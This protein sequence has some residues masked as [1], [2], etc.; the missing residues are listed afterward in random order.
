MKS[1][2]SSTHTVYKR[3]TCQSDLVEPD[4]SLFHPV[5]QSTGSWQT[6]NEKNREKITDKKTNRHKKK[7]TEQTNKKKE[8][9]R[10]PWEGRKLGCE[11]E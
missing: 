11:V 9:I 7:K 3:G 1:R 10:A 4:A 8:P 6:T 2:E 5:P